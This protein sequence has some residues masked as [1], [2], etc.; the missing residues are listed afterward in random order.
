MVTSY[1]EDFVDVYN[2]SSTE[3]KAQ[4][5]RLLPSFVTGME[6]EPHNFESASSEQA[7]FAV[8]DEDEVIEN[9]NESGLTETKQEEDNKDKEKEETE[10]EDEKESEKEIEANDSE[11]TDAKDSDESKMELDQKDDEL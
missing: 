5:D 11:K 2:E 4:S 7:E 6:L 1:W 9:N 10:A 8:Q 3:D